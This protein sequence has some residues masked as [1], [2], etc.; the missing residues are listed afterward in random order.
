MA[1]IS[2]LDNKI[3]EL[4]KEKLELGEW[5]QEGQIKLKTIKDK[6]RANKDL[7][8][9]EYE[10]LCA[11][12]AR[13]LWGMTRTQK[14]ISELK[15]EISRL[16]DLRDAERRESYGRM[17][18]AKIKELHSKYVEMSKDDTRLEVVCKMA[19]VFASELSDLL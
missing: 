17:Q 16:S 19:S 7:P 18:T 10:D 6:I 8:E 4:Q 3:L 14:R 2:E 9:G 13:I 5:K 15:L 11:D 1:N 12:Q